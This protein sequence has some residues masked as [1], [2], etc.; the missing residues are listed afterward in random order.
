ME[1]LIPP[2]V[3]A[4]FG[5][6][7]SVLYLPAIIQFLFILTSNKL[8]HAKPELLPTRWSAVQRAVWF[9]QSLDRQGFVLSFHQSQNRSPALDGLRIGDSRYSFGGV[10]AS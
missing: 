5:F 3:V 8:T 7:F 4:A 10:A 2:V 1:F 9:S 6:P